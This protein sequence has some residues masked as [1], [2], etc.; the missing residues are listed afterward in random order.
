MD[1]RALG[2]VDAVLEF[3]LDAFRRPG[4]GVHA[5]AVAGQ[6]VVH[7]M[8]RAAFQSGRQMP[9]ADIEVEQFARAVQIA[10]LGVSG[11][12]AQLVEPFMEFR[13]AGEHIARKGH[14][15]RDA[16]RLHAERRRVQQ[17]RGQ[18]GDDLHAVCVDVIS[19]AAGNRDA[20]Q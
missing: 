17:V 10:G 14:A 16:R 2:A 15:R 8:Q 9:G 5:H 20:H 7:Q 19:A 11:G 13:L 18:L 1:T 12:D 6:C 4:V 3:E